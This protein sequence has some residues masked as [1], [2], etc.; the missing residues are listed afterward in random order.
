[1]GGNVKAKAIKGDSRFDHCDRSDA[2]ADNLILP[3]YIPLRIH[4]RAFFMRPYAVRRKAGE[5]IGR[6]RLIA[7]I[8][9]GCIHFTVS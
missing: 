3:S 4:T 8:D 1:M 7:A 5:E 6:D 9:S 2:K